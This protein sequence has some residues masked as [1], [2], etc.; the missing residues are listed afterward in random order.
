MHLDNFS[1]SS[2]YGLLKKTMLVMLGQ[3]LFCRGECDRLK[4]IFIACYTLKSISKFL[5]CEDLKTSKVKK[6]HLVLVDRD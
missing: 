5:V 3:H 2:A 1:R 6:M 4:E